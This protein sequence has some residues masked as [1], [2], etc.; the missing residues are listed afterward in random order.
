MAFIDYSD[1]ATL[2]GEEILSLRRHDISGLYRLGFLFVLLL[3]L[4]AV[5]TFGQNLLMVYAGQHMMHDLRMKLFGYL[6]EMSLS[7]FDRNP[8]GRLVT[9]LT[10]DIQNL[11]EMFGS[12]IM[13]LL[14]D[15]VLL[16]GILVILFSLQWKLTL[17]TLSVMPLIVVLFRVFGVQVRGAFREIRAKL[18][19]INTTLNEYLSGI[20]VIQ[21]FRQEKETLRRFENLNHEYYR[22]TVKQIMLQ[23]VFFPG[24]QNQPW[25][26]G[27]LHLLSTDVFW[28]HPGRV[29]KIQ[30]HAICH[31]FS[32]TY[33]S[34]ARRHWAREIHLYWS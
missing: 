7:F 28:T 6:Q 32:R 17:V 21:L 12:V 13:T 11:D 34:P 20:R 29:A 16:G 22:A 1:L 15:T 31:G 2:S 9:R 23:A 26:S 18:A 10:N 5:C 24:R 33:L 30:H 8:V 19:R 27:G 25:C 4:S 14:K 3:L